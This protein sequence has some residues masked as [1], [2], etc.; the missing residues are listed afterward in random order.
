MGAQAD[1]TLPRAMCIS[2]ARDSHLPRAFLVCA[3]SLWL[4]LSVAQ[5]LDPNKLLTQYAHTAWRIQDGYFPN[6]PFWIS[7]TK[8]GYLWVGGGSGAWHFDGVRFTPWSAPIASPPVLH[9]IDVRAGEF[10]IATRSELAHV[11]DNVVISRYDLLGIDA[12]RKDIDGSVWALSN[13][14]PDRVLCQATDSKIRCFG[15]AD[16]ITIRMPFSFLPDGK[17]GFWIGGDTSLLHWKMGA[18]PEIYNFQHLQS[19][20]GQIGIHNLLQDSDGSLLVGIFAAGTGL[21]LERFRNG[22]LTPVVLPNFDGSKLVVHAIM[23][24][25]DRNLWIATF[26]SGI[27]RI[28]GQI[29]D[30]F[31]R[32]DGLSS[33]TVFDLYE[34]DDGIVW[35]ATSDGIDNFRDLPVTTFSA[36]KGPTGNASVMASKDGTVWVANLGTLDFVRNG[37]V[38]SVR[39][40]GQQVSSLLEDHLGNIWVGV[41]DGL[42]I[43]KDGRFRRI[44]EPDHH[45]LGLVVGLTEDVNG[46]IWA[47]CKGAQR[48]LLRIHDFKMSEEF[49]EPQ[50]PKAKAIAADPKGG[51]WLG[52]L[53]GDLTFFRDGIA[54]TFPLNLKNKRWAYQIAVAPDGS[55]I[56]ASDDGLVMLRSGKVQRLGKEN[57]LPCDG[58]YGFAM[59]DN[60]NLWLNAPCGFMEIAASDVQRWWIHPDT[61]VSARLFSALDGARPGPV[62][63][64]PAAKS[65]DGRIW[66]VNGVVLQMIDPSHL[67]GNGTFSPVYVEAVVAD[68]KQYKPQEGLQL[69]PLIRDLQ[70][71][72]TTPSF[73]I[74]QKVKFRYRLDGHDPD[75]QDAGTRR[76]AFYTD[77]GPGKYRFRVIASNDGAVWNEQGAT[78]D[79]AVAPAFY[80]TIWFRSLGVFLFLAVLTGFY[81]LRLRHLERQRDAL[82]RSEQELR[83]VIDT[84]PAMVWSALPDGSNTYANQRFV[85]YLGL[86]AEQTTGSGWHG[87]IHP[88]DL[89]RHVEKW[90]ESV[91]TGKPHENESRYRRSDGQHLWHLDRGVPLRDED[92]NILRWYGVTT[93]IED[94]KRAEEALQLV[95]SDL[96]DSK[97]KLEEAQRVAHVGYWEW[98]LITNDVTWSDETYRIY[99]LQPQEFPIDIAVVG[100]M[101]HPEDLESVF[102]VAEESVRGGLRTDEVHRIIRPSGE[103]RTV[104]SQGDVKKDASG[105]PYK[106]FGTVQDITDRKRADEALQRSQFYISEGQRVA[107]MGSWAFNPAGFEYWSSELFLIYGL[108]PGDKPPTV[109]EYLA[110]VHPEDRAFMKQAIAK[111]LEDQ[112]AF[113][114]TKR[115]VRPDGETR[116]VRCVGVP[117]KEGGIFQGFLGTGMDVTDQEQLVEELRLSEQYLSEGQRLAHMGSW[118]FN[119]SGLFEYWS[120]ELFRIYGL[121]PQN[122]APTLEKY[123]AT[124]HPQDRGSM[125]NTIEKMCAERIGC[126]VKK[127]IV[128]P[129]GE[130]RYIRCVGI[131]V[132]E[133]EVLKGFLGTAIDI[134]EQEL[135]SQ[136][137]KR[138][139]AYLSEAQRLTHTGSWAW[140][141][142]TDE[143][144]WS[145]EIF[146]IWEIDP[147]LKPAWSLVLDRVHP[148]D[149]ASLEQRKQMESTQKELVDSEADL[150]IL[151][152]DGRIKH[153][154]T[155][156]HP[157]RDASGRII[158]VIGTTMDV[159][160]RKRIEDSLR[161]SESHL[162]EAQKL[163]H[164]GSWAW[165]LADRKAVHLS[166]EW[167]RIYGFDPAAGAPSWEEYFERVHPEDR[168]TLK[169]IIEHSIA[170]KADYDLEFRILFSNGTVKWI[171][172]VGHPVLSD[173]RNVVGFGGSSTDITDLKSAEQ[174]REKL[175]ELEADLAHTNRV[176]TLGEMAASLAH[177]IKQP[178]AAAITSA[179]SC[180]EWLAH[181]PPNLDRARAS[182]ARIDKYGNRAAEIIDRIRSFYRKSPPQRESVDVNAIISEMLTLLKGEAD[183]YSVAMRAQ[184]AAELPKIMADRVQL[185][186]VFMNLMLNAI[187]A[188]RSEGGELTVNSQ[189][190][191]GQLQFSVSDTG[192]GLL[193]EKIDQIF[194]AFFTTKPDGSGMGLAISRSIVESHGGRLWAAANGGRGATFHF[195]LPLQVTQSSPLVA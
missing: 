56:T 180:I 125:A 119:P 33:D 70:I 6:T 182:A 97:A 149:R 42:F 183:R 175:R 110:L 167:Y 46:N 88:D 138:R 137:L 154:H 91:A 153:L 31:G 87:A 64:N 48:R 143:L 107:H 47:E 111:M 54:R 17:G 8:D 10:W 44:P 103:L 29:V 4:T 3:L 68:R 170:E 102:R 60:R 12:I 16:G 124:L 164:T 115:I 156:A 32:V 134:T 49:S 76:E 30:H 26:G 129:D 155:I 78:L 178:I 122:G 192:V 73:L 108:D 185:Q 25:S 132:V 66:F 158:E 93:D 72:Y 81:R 142:G 55:V 193:M 120:E 140:N 45:P 187:E 80:Q 63:F 128:H 144:F 104:H 52:T 146:R 166:E 34:G 9:P 24:D 184:L 43:Y 83:D 151:L 23:Q 57:G 157:V 139:Q 20:V 191:D 36:S 90:M 136:E 126:D 79:F 11:R 37:A 188:M 95:S 84:I 28:H 123:L 181:E 131:P 5:A 86:S 113:D 116:H 168:L 14:N 112:L 130:L 101:I 59:D 176:S 135:L 114:F 165:R 186:Q 2:R 15:K 53:T 67:S 141:V 1:P 105:R 133:G 50:V 147:K 77:L 75:W 106:M 94:H 121:D 27:Y 92:G 127:R 118:A 190:Q 195:T 179:N 35:A 109:E 82:R 96:Q 71:S 62:S 169:E 162:A 39:A 161:Q 100:K 98:D 172:T 7:Q 189:L 61:M 51:I 160:E 58:V 194:S 38:S 174:E 18:A 69:P 152:P 159:T 89:Q 173:A 74:P 19:I 41:D 148:D 163:T 13:Q 85:D 171:H 117:V 22:V 40:P 150:R 99:G 177:E 145:E 21:G 65:P